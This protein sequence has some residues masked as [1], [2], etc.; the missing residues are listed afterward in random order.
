MKNSYILLTLHLRIEELNF[1]SDFIVL[2][3]SLLP[4]TMGTGILKRYIFQNNNH[5]TDNCIFFTPFTRFK[6]LLRSNDFLN[7]T[8]YFFQIKKNNSYFDCLKI[9][10]LLL[11]N[12][13]I[14]EKRFLKYTTEPWHTLNGLSIT[15]ISAVSLEKYLDKQQKY[16]LENSSKQMLLKHLENE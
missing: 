16:L 1:S 8:D 11:T 7:N 13:V 12:I 14:S 4:K 3:E 5:D 6:Y 15:P 10:H 9:D 2:I